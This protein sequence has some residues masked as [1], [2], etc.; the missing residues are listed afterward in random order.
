MPEIKQH[1]FIIS[2]IALAIAILTIAVLILS[3]FQNIAISPTSQIFF[4]VIALIV[5]LG[6]FAIVA[7]AIG[8]SDRTEAFGLP[9]GSIR[10]ILSLGLLIAFVVFGIGQL[11]R[12]S[13]APLHEDKVLV[14]WEE[15]GKKDLNT[16]PDFS[17]FSL[18]LKQIEALGLLNKHQNLLANPAE[19]IVLKPV[20]NPEY[21]HL[22]KEMMATL[23]T[24]LASIL[25]FY[26][27]TRAAETGTKNSGK[28][29]G[30]AT[31]TAIEPI[32]IKSN[33]I[34]F[35]QPNIIKDDAGALGVFRIGDKILVSGGAND[36]KLVT[37]EAMS[38][39]EIKV[40]EQ[41]I[42]AEN[43]GTAEITLKK[44]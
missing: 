3:G 12:L 11:D 4:V 30:T 6:I 41:D 15:I 17:L 43:A 36:T 9:P 26:F 29:T 14:R 16:A 44:V 27:G 35:E 21:P 38:A 28:D 39:K 8:I 13:Q 31:P 34:G 42:V 19:F 2:S 25:S 1:A 20:G 22:V 10:A 24:L 7:S 37:V 23:G 5:I 40:L 18:K 32:L 33:K